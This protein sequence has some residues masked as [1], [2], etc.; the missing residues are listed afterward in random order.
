MRTDFWSGKFCADSSLEFI[1]TGF[2]N[3][4]WYPNFIDIKDNH[5]NTIYKWT[6]DIADIVISIQGGTGLSEHLG[7]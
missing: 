1:V 3:F 2:C 5:K 7:R 4:F 6:R